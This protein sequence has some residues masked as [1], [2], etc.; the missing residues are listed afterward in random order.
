MNTEETIISDNVI[1]FKPKPDMLGTYG[2][3][4]RTIPI[5]ATFLARPNGDHKSIDV[6]EYTLLLTL[7]KCA[8]L[9]LNVGGNSTPAWVDIN[10]FSNRLDLVEVLDTNDFST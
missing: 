10:R 4:L 8:K 1:E 9:H 5:G 3:W 7:E 2:P 6:M